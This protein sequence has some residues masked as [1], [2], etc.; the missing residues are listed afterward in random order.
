MCKV[1]RQA[2][3]IDK[4]PGGRRGPTWVKEESGRMRRPR[5]KS[6]RSCTKGKDVIS[7]KWGLWQPA[8]MDKNIGSEL[9]TNHEA[10]TINLAGRK[11]H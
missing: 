8:C 11:G 5:T 1:G 3:V 6:T 7:P 9:T 2:S 10:E 4:L